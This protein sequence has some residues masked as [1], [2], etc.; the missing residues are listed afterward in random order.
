MNVRNVF[1]FHYPPLS[2]FSSPLSSPSIPLSACSMAAYRIAGNVRVFEGRAVNAKIKTGRNSHAPVF[3]MQSLWWVWFLGIETRILQLRNF[4]WGLS[5]HSVKICTL[6]MSR[7][8][9]G[10]MLYTIFIFLQGFVV[11]DLSQHFNALIIFIE[12][13]YYGQ[14]LPFGADSYKDAQHLQYL[15]SQQALA[16]FASVITELKVRANIIIS[17][18]PHYFESRADP[19]QYIQ[20]SYI[21]RRLL[22]R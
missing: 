18:Q 2:P 10:I 11:E 1:T 14:S 19:V 16:D 13:R 6:E 3:H 15:S 9:D 12:H 17:R 7:Y 4:F 8:T 5:S 21:C 20:S 22:W